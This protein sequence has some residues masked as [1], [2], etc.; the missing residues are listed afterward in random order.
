[1]NNNLLYHNTVWR[2]NQRFGPKINTETI[3]FN[4]YVGYAVQRSFT[5]LASRSST[6]LET[7]SLAV[8]GRFFFGDWRP[9]YSVSKNF[10]KGLGSLN[11]NPL[12]INAGIE[13][14]LSKKNSLFLTFNV[15]DVLK[16]NNFVQQNITPQGFTNTLSNTLSRYFMIGLRANFQHWGGRPKRNGKDLNRKG[17]GSFIY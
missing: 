2:V 6:N 13:K 9:N 3:E 15:F 17:D 12:I 14:Q 16:Q 11:T 7:I 4:P 5:T 10:V 8:D 1:M